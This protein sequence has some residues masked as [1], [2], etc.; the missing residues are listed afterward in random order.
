MP[1]GEK[2]KGSPADQVVV[3]GYNSK[4]PYRQPR[5]LRS[6]LYN[7]SKMDFPPIRD[8]CEAV[9]KIDHNTLMLSVC[10][11]DGNQETIETKFGKFPRGSALG[12][13]QKQSS[14]YILNI[15]DEEFPPLPMDNFMCNEVHTVLDRSKAVSFTAIQVDQEESRTIEQMTRLQSDDPKWHAVRR[16]RLTASVAGD[17][18]KRRAGLLYTIY[19]MKCQL[20]LGL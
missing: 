14:H 4:S 9:A 19:Y 1:R 13:Q 11:L 2:L 16:D 7:P 8:L 3:C 10:N 20:M 5:G 17:I 6:T 15:L 18:V 12:Y